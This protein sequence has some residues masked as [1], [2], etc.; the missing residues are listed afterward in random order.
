[1]RVLTARYARKFNLGNYESEEVAMEASFNSEDVV[2]EFG[3][4]K[5]LVLEMGGIQIAKACNCKKEEVKDEPPKEEVKEEPPKE[6][7]TKEPEAKPVDD[8]PKKDKPKKKA[9][10]KKKAKV[11]VYS[12]ESKDHKEHLAAILDELYPNWRKE[13]AEKAAAT[14]KS[15]HD[16]VAIFDDKGEITSDFREAIIQGME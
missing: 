5:A 9:P 12:R 10:R 14:S 11:V 2:K 16:T 13:L 6:E 3:Q 7:P 15:M 8:K 1:M 4:L